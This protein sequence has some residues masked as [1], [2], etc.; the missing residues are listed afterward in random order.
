MSR[1]F[2]VRAPSH[3]R[4]GEDEPEEKARAFAP[5]CSEPGG[6]VTVPPIGSL[7]YVSHEAATVA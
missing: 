6:S 3:L 4:L 5:A 1:F 7:D 2:G